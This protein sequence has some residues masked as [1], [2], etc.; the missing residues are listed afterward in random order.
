MKSKSI[1]IFL[2]ALTL[3]LTVLPSCNN[4]DSS[5]Q[6]TL[7]M[8]PTMAEYML[9]GVK[10]NE[11]C[12][13]KGKGTFL[14]NKYSQAY[15]DQ[16][17][18]LIL[19]LSAE[20]ISEWKNTFTV[21]QILQCVLGDTRDIGITVDYSKDFMDFMKDA[22]TCGYEISEDFTTVIE[23]P[24]DNS[25]YFPFISVAC[26]V[27]QIFEGKTCTQVKAVH[28]QVDENGEVFDIYTYPDDA[29]NQAND[30]E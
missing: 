21:L 24:E 19:T 5:E 13:S 1:L 29:E 30:I 3:I 2:L 4:K 8:S 22:H 9:A 10:A 26:T 11:F 28:M 27:M 25:W 7:H 18:C 15:I 14:E 12:E 6:V 16:D 20:T 17:G 23:S